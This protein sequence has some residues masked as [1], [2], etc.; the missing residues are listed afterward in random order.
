[1]RAADTKESTT[2]MSRTI[3][4][5]FVVAPPA[6]VRIRTRLG[7]SAVDETVL[8]QI[9]DYL[10]HLA[11]SDLAERCGLGL[12]D[13]ERFRRKRALIGATSSRWAGTISRTSDNQWQR[14]Y[15]NLLD[16]RT[17]LRRAIGRLRARLAAPVGGRSGRAR[18]YASQDERWQ[19]QRRLDLLTA[20]LARVEA[21]IA[22]GRVSVVRGGRRLLH[23]RQHL[24]AAGLT[25]SQWRRR[26]QAARWFLT[27]DGDAGYPLGNGTILVD[28]ERAGWS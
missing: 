15:R 1:M 13:S 11:G 14:A 26:W 18:G 5:P 2:Q 22:D 25:E 24:E 16:Q 9:G 19:K 4:A 17:G 27:A 12:A 6:G 28:P 21:R 7:I 23:T 10:G 20:R 3:A 8:C